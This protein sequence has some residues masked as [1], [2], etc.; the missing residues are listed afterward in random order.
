MEYHSN[1]IYLEIKTDFSIE[2]GTYEIHAHKVTDGQDP[3]HHIYNDL[4]L[5][6]EDKK[7]LV[8]DLGRKGSSDVADWFKDE[9]S[10]SQN[11]LDEDPIEL[12]FAFRGTL[13]L[14]ISDGRT[15]K[16]KDVGFAQGND[17]TNNDWW[18]ASQSGQYIGDNQITF[19]GTDQDGNSIIATA[20][21]AG[22]GNS[23]DTVNITSIS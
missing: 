12:N 8:F 16:F 21:C 1:H 2:S 19:S 13:T 5:D 23:E 22:V 14:V 6:I 9:F 20:Q 15:L 3:D 18:F 4:T 10:S 7:E 17:L 11:T